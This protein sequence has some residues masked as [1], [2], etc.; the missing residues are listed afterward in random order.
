[1]PAGAKRQTN[2]Q[3]FNK[4]YKQQINQAN[5]KKDISKLTGIPTRILDDVFDRGVGAFKTN[6]KSVRPSVKSPEQWAFGRVYSFVM[7]QKGTW[8]GA[9]KDLADKV[10][11]K[12]IKGYIK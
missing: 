10:R 6:P 3:K 1:M 12:K 7:K 4:K 8:S 9:D 5:S 2:K 11:K